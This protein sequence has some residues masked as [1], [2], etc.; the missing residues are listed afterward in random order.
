MNSQRKVIYEQRRAVLGGEDMSEQVREWIDEVIERTVAEFTQE[1]YAEEWD[2]EGLVK[3]MAM[4]YETEITVDEL[5]EELGDFSR[6][7]LVEEFQE[8]AGDE[9]KAKEEELTPELMR[10]LK[11]VTGRDPTKTAA[12]H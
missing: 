8:D 4:L 7:S 11:R 6:E 5:R 10:E 1:E 2:L 3:Q 12:G 9:Y